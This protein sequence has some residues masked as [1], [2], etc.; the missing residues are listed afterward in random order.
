M[1]TLKVMSIISL[2]ITGFAMI[3]F[4]KSE[5]IVSFDTAWGW[6]TILALWSVAF[7]IV[8]LVQAKKTQNKKI[9]LYEELEKLPY[10][11]ESN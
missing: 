9:K 7:S 2:V 5:E 11:N 6:A 10:Y 4:Y 3:A 1:K 8:V